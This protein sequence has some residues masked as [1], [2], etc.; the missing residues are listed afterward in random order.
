[1]TDILLIGGVALDDKFGIP[2]ALVLVGPPLLNHMAGAGTHL[3]ATV[4]QFAT[5]LPRTMVNILGH[6]N[7]A[8]SACLVCHKIVVHLQ[9]SCIIAACLAQAWGMHQGYILLHLG[10]NPDHMSASN[11]FMHSFH[12]R[13]AMKPQLTTTMSR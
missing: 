9:S 3:L 7:S 13:F 4:P 11:H 2:K 1:M 12:G 10:L 5:G 6:M 8:I